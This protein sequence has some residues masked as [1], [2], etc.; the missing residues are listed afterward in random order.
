MQYLQLLN[1]PEFHCSGNTCWFGH[2]SHKYLGLKNE[3]FL[4]T[5][6]P[7]N[8]TIEC[9]LYLLK[10]WGQHCPSLNVGWSHFTGG[11]S[12]F[13]QSTVPFWNK[14]SWSFLH[15]SY[16]TWIRLIFTYK[17]QFNLIIAVP[18]KLVKLPKHSGLLNFVF[19]SKKKIE[20]L[21]LPVNV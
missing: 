19:M 6:P 20:L 5:P 16:I 18:Y 1:Q 9:I 12:S 4:M 8:D 13:L 7:P 15:M 14:Q 10:H 3:E 2:M 11:Q 21:K 17:T